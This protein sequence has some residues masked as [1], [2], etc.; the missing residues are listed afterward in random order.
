MKQNLALLAGA[1]AVAGV[2]YVLNPEGSA[3]IGLTAIKTVGILLACSVP[4]LAAGLVIYLSNRG[5]F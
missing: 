4:L 5:D 2:L 3:V 1:A